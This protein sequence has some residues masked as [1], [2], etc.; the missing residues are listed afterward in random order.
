V[1]PFLKWPGGKRWLVASHS[2]WLIRSE[3]QHIEPFLGGGAVFFHLRPNISILTDSNEELIDTYSAIRDD[4]QGVFEQLRRHHSRHCSSYYYLMRS[5]KPRTTVSRAARFLYLNRTCF[6]G[7]YRVNLKGVFNV[8]IGSK[9]SVLLSTDDFSATSR[10]LS[11]AEL[12]VSDFEKAIS[13]A[14]DGDFVYADPPYTVKHNNNN[15]VKYNEKIFSWSD[16]IRLAKAVRSAASRGAYIM[17]SNADHLSVRELYADSIWSC[18][19][20]S[21]YSRLASSSEYRRGT[22]ELIVTNYLSDDGDILSPRG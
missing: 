12:M 10:L 14:G 18:S 11:G 3:G 7:L 8:P 21:R 19:S 2:E 22:T 5:R 17:I 9:T 15:F 13:R 20:V 6:N 16:Q 1:A 4:P